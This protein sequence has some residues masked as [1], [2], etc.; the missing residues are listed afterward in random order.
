MHLVGFIIRIYA[1]LVQNV[2]GRGASSSAI[3]SG[4]LHNVILTVTSEVETHNVF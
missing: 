4:I 1:I 3:G 2:S